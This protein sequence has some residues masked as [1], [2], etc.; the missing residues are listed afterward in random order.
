MSVEHFSPDRTLLQNEGLRNYD[1]DTTY[2][3]HKKKYRSLLSTIVMSRFSQHQSWNWNASLENFTR[4]Y[5]F[6]WNL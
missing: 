5:N 2:H 4:N 3:C 1:K 6:D